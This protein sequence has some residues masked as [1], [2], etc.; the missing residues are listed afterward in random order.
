[1]HKI[2]QYGLWTGSALALAL[3]LVA[4]GT[5]GSKNRCSS[6]NDC[7]GDRVCTQNQTCSSIGTS[8]DQGPNL[9]AIGEEQGPTPSSGGGSGGGASTGTGAGSSGA[10][11]GGPSPSPQQ[12]EPVNTTRPGGGGSSGTSQGGPEIPPPPNGTSQGLDL[13]EVVY[14]WIY[15]ESPDCENACV[16]AAAPATTPQ[17]ERLLAC[18][19]ACVDYDGYEYEDCLA[20]FC[21]DDYEDVNE[22]LFNA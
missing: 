18:M 6:D 8:L 3:T 17:I 1:M 2:T 4:C 15:C 11:Q 9:P 16:E 5:N 20:R 10:S 13:C 7:A 19:D 21:P 12:D 22:C 14:C